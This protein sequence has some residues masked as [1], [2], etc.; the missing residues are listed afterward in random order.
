MWPT[1]RRTLVTIITSVGRFSKIFDIYRSYIALKKIF[2]LLKLI[3]NNIFVHISN[4]VSR[5]D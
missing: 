4:R 2:L 1:N 5:N 3:Y